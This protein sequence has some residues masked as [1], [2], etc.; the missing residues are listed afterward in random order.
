VNEDDRTRTHAGSVLT[1][2][3]PDSIEVT[4]FSLYVVEPARAWHA[5]GPRCAI[6]SHASNDLVIDHPTVSRFHCEIEVSER[7]ARIVDRQSTNGTIVDGVHVESAWLKDGSMV[8]LGAIAVRFAWGAQRLRVSLSERHRFGSL[9]GASIAM[10]EAF[11]V[12]ERCA[13]SDATVLVTGETGTGKEGAAEGIHEESARA[14]GPFEV[15][16]CASIPPALL[17]SQLFGH[18]E[19]A[20]TGAKSAHAGAFERANGGTVFLD[21]IGELP[22][23]LQPKLLRVLE[24]RSI[25]RVGGTAR[26]PIDVRVIAATRR[27]L[28]AEVN[29]GTFRSDLYYRLAVLRVHLP[30]LRDRLEDLPLLVEA[31]LDRLGVDDTERARLSSAASL[32][33]LAASTWPGNVRELR[34]ALERALVLEAEA[35]PTAPPAPAYAIDPRLGWTEAKQLAQ[36]DFERRYLAALL[37]HHEDNVT[38]AAR[39][40]G[41]DRVYLHR[42]LRRHGLRG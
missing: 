11:A 18:E 8:S 5:E 6:G 26:T 29:A 32:R 34:N 33:R 36:D 30:A 9:V 37:A 14:D 15:I 20:F 7:G 27:S 23:D 39:A 10:R 19:G 21:E 38:R 13:K 42:L 24:E 40:A 41:M 4:R 1:T 31:L 17:E 35:D 25:R 28:E 2:A 22:A 3:P 12:L 16:D